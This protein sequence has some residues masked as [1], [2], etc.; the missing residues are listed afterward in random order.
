MRDEDLAANLAHQL[1]RLLAMRRVSAK[2]M[3]RDQLGR[4]FFARGENLET[5]NFRDPKAI[6]IKAYLPFV[7]GG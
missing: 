1:D 5:P 3:A 2:L 6:L 7:E 4:D